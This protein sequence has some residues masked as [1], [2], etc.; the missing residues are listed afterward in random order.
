MKNFFNFKNQIISFENALKCCILMAWL[1][2]AAS[3][4]LEGAVN[5]PTFHLDG[6]FQTAS[7]LYRLDAGQFPGKDFFPYL[8]VGPL[9]V[10]Y[11]S[12][13]LMG[14]NI[15]ASTFSAQFI[16]LVFGWVSVALIWQFIWR[17]KYLLTS[18]AI[19]SF[20]FFMPLAVSHFFM[21]PLPDWVAFQTS[22]GNSLRP[23]RAF[24]PYLIGALYYY[25][26][27][28]ITSLQ[29]KYLFLGFITGLILLWSND[30]AIPTAFLFMWLILANA[31]YCKEFN[32]KEICIYLGTALISW[33]T[34][35][36][37]VTKGHPVELLQYNYIDVANDQ[38]WFF[39]SYDE[40]ARILNI[41]QLGLLFPETRRPLI[42]LAFMLILWTRTKSTEL[43]LVIWI[44]VVLLAGGVLASVGGHVGGYFGGFYFWAMTAFGITLSRLAWLGLPSDL[45]KVRIE[46]PNFPIIISYFAFSV[47]F[48]FMYLSIQSLNLATS[49]AAKDP[50]R[51]YV[52]ELGGYLGVEWRGYINLARSTNEVKVFE[53]YWG[54]WS[55]TRRIFPDWP[56][57]AVIHALGSVR[58]KAADLVKNG[59]VIITSRESAM[60]NWVGWNMSESYWFYKDLLREWKPIYQSP[61]TTVWQKGSQN[62]LSIEVPC[63]IID[64]N[65]MIISVDRPGFLEVDVSYLVDGV[66]S[67]FLLDNNFSFS[68][69]TKGAVSLNPKAHSALMPA[70]A[71]KKGENVY[72]AHFYPKNRNADS[73]LHSCK[74]KLLVGNLVYGN[75]VAPP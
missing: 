26:S 17:P 7:G 11:P 60:P 61:M 50:K 52:E 13:K 15:F 10:L 72:N 8:G 23:I 49:T 38:W 46:P 53:E 59:Q 47:A 68:P 56:V 25:F 55:A 3:Y 69:V 39:G 31:L 12:F 4:S 35:L 16:V 22:P 20:L 62:V 66:R 73:K 41:Q 34:L 48:F 30:F 28:R 70:Y 2:W 54:L 74:A 33:A 18:L 36:F 21:L 9:L 24:A 63:Q 40:S 32:L 29:N 6:A 64:G 67:L 43:M 45:G 51:F 75:M 71:S 27:P 57:D 42:V 19:S 58:T 1:V 65:K 5:I 37:I 14:G 44:G